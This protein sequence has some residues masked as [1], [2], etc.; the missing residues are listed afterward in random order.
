MAVAPATKNSA[1]HPAWQT[2][3]A[4]EE[5]RESLAALFA[6]RRSFE[7]GLE[8]AEAERRLLEF[9][10][11]EPE[12]IHRTPPLLEFPRFC[13]NPLVLILLSASVTSV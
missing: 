2:T 10:P 3:R 4:G 5:Q 8:S 1:T 9:G 11:N 12:E 13:T 7:R 6:R